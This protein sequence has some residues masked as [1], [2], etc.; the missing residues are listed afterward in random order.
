MLPDNY[1]ITFGLHS[2]K[3]LQDIKT[4]HPDYVRAF[5]SNSRLCVNESNIREYF[6]MPTFLPFLKK[7][8]TELKG[9]DH[10]EPEGKQTSPIGK[11]R[12]Q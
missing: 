10:K 3:T 6:S 1:K 8:Y 4:N 9:E 12:K 5:L 7:Q 11:S 2:G